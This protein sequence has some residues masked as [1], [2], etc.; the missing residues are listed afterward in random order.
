VSVIREFARGLGV[1]RD[2]R[3][4]RNPVRR[5]GAGADALERSRLAIVALD[6]ALEQ[7]AE[8]GPGPDRS[9][10]ALRMLSSLEATHARRGREGEEVRT[11]DNARLVHSADW[12]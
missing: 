5:S 11:D 7:R 3:P 9:V 1:K 8:L 6:C 2:L 4:R 12:V 10:G